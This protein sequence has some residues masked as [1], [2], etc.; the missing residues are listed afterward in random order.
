[1]L[2]HIDYVV[3]NF[4]VDYVTIGTDVA[5]SSSASEQAYRKI[6]KR[7]SL[8]SRWEALW[9]PN[10]FGP[11]WRQEHQI[12]SL[13]WTNWPV[14]TIGMVQQGYSDDDIQK[15]LGGNVLRVARAA[16]PT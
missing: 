7:R 6:P 16:L 15:I 5:H 9:H 10:E 4:G 11:E 12:L 13:A 3:K 2:D 1:M 8:R 14:F